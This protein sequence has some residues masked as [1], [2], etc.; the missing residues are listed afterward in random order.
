[1]TILFRQDKAGIF[2][3]LII[4]LQGKLKPN[5]SFP[6]EKWVCLLISM[7]SLKHHINELAYAAKTSILNANMLLCLKDGSIKINLLTHIIYVYTM[8]IHLTFALLTF[9]SCRTCWRI[10]LP[11]HMSY[12]PYFVL[13]TLEI[14]AYIWLICHI[15]ASLQIYPPNSFIPPLIYFIG[16]SF[17]T[18]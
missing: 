14:T 9:L 5:P 18:T 1:M 2:I 10:T 8:Y 11:R 4:S 6:F 12:T 7:A 17:E 13:P 16:T 3:K 15:T